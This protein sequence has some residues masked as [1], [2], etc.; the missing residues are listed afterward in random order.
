[1]SLMWHCESANSPAVTMMVMSGER[2]QRALQLW[3]WMY[4]GEMIGNLDE[5]INKCNGFSEGYR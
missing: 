4:C 1:M 3:R 5:T 2:P